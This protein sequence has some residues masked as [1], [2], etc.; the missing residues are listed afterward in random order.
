MNAARGTLAADIRVERPAV[1]ADLAASASSAAVSRRLAHERDPVFVIHG[2]NRQSGLSAEDSHSLISRVN[3]LIGGVS[4]RFFTVYWPADV[5]HYWD[6]VR[7]SLPT[8]K[9]F[10]DFMLA[11]G[12]W[13][14]KR[15]ITIIAHSLGCRVALETLRELKARTQGQARRHNLRVLLMAAA[16]PVAQAT[17]GA[18]LFAPSTMADAVDVYYSPTDEVLLTLFGAGQRL[19]GTGETGQAVGL[20]G[21][22]PSGPWAARRW[23]QWYRHGSYWKGAEM[24]REVERA[25]SRARQLPTRQVSERSAP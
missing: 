10:A 12:I 16:I 21:G 25:I 19:A 24:A 3:G 17:P 5:R 22:P 7:L 13:S 15:S 14:D 23:M 6:A 1:D 8:A 20:F 9:A 18:A 11:R 2:W 4:E